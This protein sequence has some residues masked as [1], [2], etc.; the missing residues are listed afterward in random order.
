MATIPVFDGHNDTVLSLRETGRSFFDRSSQGHVDLP[1]AN[2]GGLI[3]GF[4]AV[5]VPNPDEA[6]IDPDSDDLT[7]SSYGSVESMPPI[8]PLATAE[9]FALD[10]LATLA[11][12]ARSSDGKVAIVR[13]A[14]DIRH[15]MKNGVFS[16]ELHIEGAEPIDPSLNTLE[17]FYLAGVRSIGMVWS[18]PN[19]F[20]N[21]VPF[22]FPG[23]PDTGPGL[24]DAGKALVA[25][26]D[27]LGIVVDMSHLNEAGFWNIAGISKNPLVCTHSGVH[28]LSPSTRNLTDKQ[29]DAIKDSEGIVGVNFHVGFINSEG[30][31]DPDKTS[32]SHLADHVDYMCERLGTDKVALGSDFDGATMPGDLKDAAGL[33]LLMAELVR[34][35]YDDTTLR[36]IGVE[37]WLRIFDRTWKN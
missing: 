36:A 32:V 14:D 16:M 4:F 34:R 12:V 15:N 37:N 1:R 21:G 20:A 24:T 3:G 27:E 23:S 6:E 30:S 19:A 18:R 10:A 31:R 9:H 33:P 8:L 22:Q 7:T 28:A 25:A 17:T 2:D 13:T 5:W 11:S 29:L 26:C 35:G